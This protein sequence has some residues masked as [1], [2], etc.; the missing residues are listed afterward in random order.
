MAKSLRLQFRNHKALFETKDEALQFLKDI[1]NE[2]H[3]SSQKFGN[4]LYA[5][6]MVVKYKDED[7][8][9]QVILAI[10]IDN[11]KSEYHLI[12][13]A[14]IKKDLANEILRA[15]Q[16]DNELN[17]AILNE[18]A[19]R[20]EADT[21]LDTKITAE[22][23]RATVAEDE[24]KR[25]LSTKIVAAGSSEANVL[26]EYHLVDGDGRV[27]GEPIKIFKDSAF[28]TA[29]HGFKGARGVEFNP[30]TNEY[31]LLYASDKDESVEFIYFVY[32]N[33]EGV[34][35]IIGLNF[36]DY[37]QE[38]EFGD[39]LKVQNHKVSI[40]VDPTDEGY[41]KVSSNGIKT[42]GIDTKITEEAQNAL[43]LSKEYTDEVADELR[44]NKVFSEDLKVELT[45]SGTKLT[46]LVDEKTIGKEDGINYADKLPRLH[47]LTKIKKVETNDA[48]V[49][50]AYQLQDA[51]GNKIGDTISVPV[52]SALVSVKQAGTQ[53]TIDNNTG[54]YIDFVAGNEYLNFV[55]KTIN[56]TFE[57]VSIPISRYFNDAH[58]GFG[59]ANRDGVV[60]LKPSIANEYL[61]VE[62]DSIGVIGVKQDIRL[63]KETA[64]NESKEYSDAKDVELKE[65]IDNEIVAA[66]ADKVVD[67]DY[68]GGNKKIYLKKADG[69]FSTGFDASDFLVDG[70]LKN[71]EFNNEFNQLTF[72]WNTDAEDKVIVVPLSKFVDAYTVGNSSRSFLSINDYTV[73]AIVDSEVYTNSL[74]STNYVSTKAGE[75]LEATKTY[76]DGKIAEETLA[77]QQYVDNNIVNKTKEAVEIK[78]KSDLL[79]D[80]TPITNI[81]LEEARRCSLLREVNTNGERRYFVDNEATSMLYKKQDGTLVNLNEYITSLENRVATLEEQMRDVLTNFETKVQDALLNT[82]YFKG[83]N[84]EIKISK[85]VSNIVEIGFADDAVFGNII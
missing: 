59:L 63:A 51:E 52:E 31:D 56:G 60:S 43:D 22:I 71:V 34:L 73:D 6:P 80:G 84:R 39:G 13:T 62:Q 4:S 32:E 83:T 53:S 28:V 14:S 76:V 46:L 15:V 66:L 10:G 19:V 27:L 82:R 1:V 57:L 67:V 2:E 58:F 45:V 17:E 9:V 75:T 3:V 25:T 7:D 47:S 69:T 23:E 55:Y 38:S 20:E 35:S 30:N 49:K 44:L 78:F 79:T 16:K 42:E 85:N 48:S 61:V 41:I 36:D 8:M 70:A 5:E 74:A 18:I 81:T 24:I 50:V 37:I 54:E 29:L 65:T 64:I 11:E 21:N 26:E 12:D 33:K 40:K 72:T 77:I 68:D